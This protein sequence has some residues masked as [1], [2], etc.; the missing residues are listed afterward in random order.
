M[1]E[2]RLCFD[3]TVEWYTYGDSLVGEIDQM[4]ISEPRKLKNI[5]L[6]LAMIGETFRYRLLVVA[7]DV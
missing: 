4:M 5:K 1:V 6:T 7:T 2:V 3:D